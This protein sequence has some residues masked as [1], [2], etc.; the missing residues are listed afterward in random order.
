MSFIKNIFN[1]FAKPNLENPPIGL[2]T[3]D[4]GAVSLQ[5]SGNDLLNLFVATVRGLDDERLGELMEKSAKESLFYTLKIVAYVRDIRG[6]KG[7]RDL[8]RKMMEWLLEHDERQLYANM[9]AYISE[10]G[11]WDD[12]VYLRKSI[13]RKH[14]IELL[15]NQLR[16]DIVNMVNL[17]S[18]S[19]AAKWVPSEASIINK[20]TGILFSL[21][22][23]MG[24]SPAILRKTYISP[25]RKYID[26]LERKMCAKEWNTVDYEKVPSVA[27]LK[28]GRPDRAF[29]RNDRERFEEYKNKLVSGKAK[30]NARALFPHDIVSQY[31]GADKSDPIMESQWKEMVEK[32]RELGSLD[33]VL[34]LSDVS[35]SMEGT[36]MLISYTMGLLISSLNKSEL[37][38]NK[39]LTFESIPQFV[40]VEGETLFDRLAKIKNA[41]WGGSTNI[42]S[43]FELILKKV[44][45]TDATM[46]DKIIIVSDM[47]F[48]EADNAYATNYDSIIMKFEEAGYKIPHIVFWNVNGSS[49]DFQVASDTPNVSMISGFSTDILKCVLEARPPTPYDTMMAALNDPRYDLIRCV[50]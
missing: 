29:Q 33:N 2:T 20:K 23:N 26:V 45:G 19:L 16:D 22:K 30:I 18:V 1:I 40:N 35:A 39:I 37:F 11:R 8:G 6:G 49:K 4:N 46:P 36:P 42:C 14:Y 43:A 28:H 15:A 47:Q 48:N 32:M 10:Y 44:K 25:L 7:E 41:P 31:L 21:A 9:K 3:T 12:G 13:A 50:V 17:K 34:V 38:Q 24:L 27:M 5:S